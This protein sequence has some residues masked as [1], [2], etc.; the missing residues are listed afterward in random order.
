LWI[1]GCDFLSQPTVLY[2]NGWKELNRGNLEVAMR[3]ADR[4]LKL[5]QSPKS[6]WH[7]RFS[8][9]KA[10][11][12][13]WQHLNEQ[14]LALNEPDLPQSLSSS[15]LAVWRKLSQTVASA[16]THQLP[17]AHQY[18]DEA[19]TLATAHHPELLGQV[20]LRRGTV[21]FWEGKLAD[22]QTGYRSALQLSREEKNQF[23]EAA[24]LGSLGV[25]AAKQEHY[26]ECLEWNRA[27][28]QLS[29]DIGA[30]G[31]VARIL[32]NM[33]WAL[34]E[35]G[36]YDNALSNYR[37]A[38]EASSRNG[39]I[40]DALYWRTGISSVYY[41]RR[42][43][44]VAR[45]VLEQALNDA[46]RQDDKSITTEYLND[47]SSLAIETGSSDA[48]DAF[49]R[50]A[51]ALEQA[52][53]D[54]SGV[55]DTML[56]R[57]R[58]DQM[59]DRYGEAER[60]FQALSNNVAASAALR[61]EAEAR[62]A[63][64]YDDENR[65]KKA[66]QE[67]QRSITTI[68]TA[69]RSIQ[70]DE[71]RLAFLSSA[72]DFYDDYVD[73][74]MQH[75]RV[76]DALRIADLTRSQTLVEGL[77]SSSKSPAISAVNLSPRE[78]AR[79][80]HATLLVYWLGQN[81][82]YL[83]VV[84]PAKVAY[85]PLPAKSQIDPT[86][87]SYR[88]AIIDGRDVLN[89]NA[90]SGEQLYATLVAPAQ[91]LIPQNSRVILFPAESLYGLNFETLIVPGA[92]PHFWIE[93]VTLST[94]SALAMPPSA[95]Q[96]TSSKEKNLLLVGDPEPASPDFPRLAQAPAEMQKIS[97]HFAQA[98]RDVLEG[99]GATPAS[100]LSSNP[101]RFSYLHFVTH[102]TASHT[103]PLESAVIL[104]KEGDSYKLYARDIV[105]HPLNAELVTISACNGAGTRAY[106]GEGL[107][108]LSWAFLRA[109]A[110]N[111]IGALW[112]VSDA[113]STPQLMDAMYAGIDKGQD[114]ATALRNAKL[115]I[116]HA[117]SGSVFKKPFYWAPFQLYTGS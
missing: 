105:Q 108:G 60:S 52:G 33:G 87:K 80:L 84:T 59:N 75:H 38:E 110:H 25:V 77:T 15:D 43:F 95:T 36:D 91:K 55:L 99:P 16:Y 21:F 116:L 37:Q 86:V 81:H 47:L 74:L 113:S 30:Q 106:A 103:R 1:C 53:R 69:R 41:L 23:L 54:E 27:A 93:D 48:A 4:G 58:I 94:A 44:P 12:L 62:L 66:V 18:L 46:R 11:I 35:L 32:G 6:E 102:G 14:S 70:E 82:S 50:E 2:E 65:P 88:Q 89:A 42:E 79:K 68:Q 71:L 109:G 117:G 7:W 24:A 98:N 115:A 5:H 96:R 13:V 100:Y 8:V 3:D 9:L 76:E 83:W 56:L 49:S 31:S 57:G 20:A 29:Q 73:F 97:N 112:E 107:V 26:D 19:E 85:F 92:S 67:Y 17:H 114:P 104:S 111:V 78:L 40:G 64:V 72:I 45:L 90:K 34:R 61:W 63:K 51:A 39:Q 10:E 28:L 22:A 101:G